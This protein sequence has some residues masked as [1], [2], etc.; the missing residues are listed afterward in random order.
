MIV[1]VIVLDDCPIDTLPF[2]CCNG[3]CFCIINRKKKI[4]FSRND[5]KPKQ[6]HLNSIYVH[7][8]DKNAMFR[9]E[10]YD[11][12]QFFNS[13]IID[14][15]YMIFYYGLN[16]KF[17]NCLKPLTALLI[18]ISWESHYMLL[19]TVHLTFQRNVLFLYNH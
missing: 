2:L 3:K 6:Q 13:F 8:Y 9:W 7:I 15:N 10:N 4:V 16:D 19:S 5:K 14:T 1:I 12:A 18:C 17:C 11:L